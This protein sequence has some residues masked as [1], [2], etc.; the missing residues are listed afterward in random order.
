MAIRTELQLRLPHSPGALADI[1]RTLARERVRTLALS[2]ES[3]G[4]V[5][6][7]VDNVE[8]AA[9]VLRS[10]HVRVD[11][12]DVLCATVPTTS[13]DAVLSNVAAAGITLQYAYA[14]AGEAT[15]TL[16][17][18][19]GVDNALAASAATGI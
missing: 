10:Q 19:L 3:S 9:H 14:G 6:C 16:T 11:T 4:L 13:L 5:R 8:R 12:R 2:L 17:L 18:V 1:L 7:L 15:G